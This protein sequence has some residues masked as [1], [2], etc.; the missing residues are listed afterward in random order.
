MVQ[1][2]IGY[3]QT[4]DALHLR[5]HTESWMPDDDL[6]AAIL[7]VHGIGEHIGR[8]THVAEYLAEKSYAV[9]GL[10]H[11]THGRSEGQ[12]RVYMPDFDPVVN[13]LKQ[14]FDHIRSA[15]PDKRIFIYGHSLGSFLATLFTL[16]Y[17]DQL[18]GFVSSG[19]PLLIDSL[20]SSLVKTTGNLLAAVAPKLPLI[21]LEL[22]GISRDPAVIAAYNAD[23]LVHRLPVR[24][25]MA[26]GYNNAISSIR[27]QVATLRLPLLVLHGG[28][29]PITPV[30][31][32]QWLFE[33][34][35]SADKTLKIYPGLYH[36]I[37]NEPEKAAVLADIAGWLDHQLEKAQ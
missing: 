34:A 8:Y 10:D 35:A 22:K 29:D 23:S 24:V 31:G 25:G 18:A 37:H 5:I 33:K 7:L 2:T 13:D 14:Y 17:Q 36:E 12:P 27:E 20:F 32:S 11:R 3:F 16:R 26:V 6:K 28:D 1:H 30:S 4:A 21:P 9:F 15:H 19:S